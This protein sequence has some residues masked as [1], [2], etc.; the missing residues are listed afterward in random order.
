MIVL[1]SKTG[2]GL[3]SVRSTFT[4]QLPAHYIDLD[5]IVLLGFKLL[6]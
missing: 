5:F 1:L 2:S 4:D 3:V 6:L